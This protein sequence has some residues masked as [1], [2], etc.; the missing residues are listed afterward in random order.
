MVYDY[1]IIGGGIVGLATARAILRR[2][3]GASLI[4]LEK[5]PEI[6]LHQTGRNSGVIHSGIYYAPGSL[7]AKLC[8]LGLKATKQ[9][10]ID[11]C[12]PFEE[13]GKLIVATSEAELGR[14]SM[15]GERAKANGINAQPL[16]AAEIK[17]REPNVA[18]IAALQIPS[19]SIVDYRVLIGRLATEVQALSGEVRLSSKVVRAVESSDE[20]RVVVADGNDIRSHHLVA[21][22][23]L[24]ADRLAIASGLAVQH[25]IVPFRGEYFELPERL[26]S[27]VTSMIY[28]VPDPALPFLGI[29]VTPTMHG[30]VTLGPNAV[31]A[32][33][34]EGYRKSDVSL[35]DIATYATFPGFWRTIKGNL[36]SG[37]SEMMNSL[38]RQRY[39]A[40]CQRYIPS[41]QLEDLTPARAGVRAQ[42]V[43][44]DGTLVHDFLFERTPRM[45]HVLNA[46][47]PAATAAL[48]IAEMIA[49]RL[50]GAAHI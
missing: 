12:I 18:G 25:Q 13:R 41:L 4:L 19:T 26:K 3:P 2:Y 20:V 16:K 49:D 48:P 8:A 50:K 15:L 27:V 29:H 7:K 40:V 11:Q 38:S 36:S 43:A 31:L 28:P 14:L 47:S 35:R 24:F 30:G 42:A 9:Y 1:C 5:E 6:G 22:A 34:R 23:G 33:A 37:V 17:E 10:C 32:L 44:R 21:C 45:L 39:L 46:P